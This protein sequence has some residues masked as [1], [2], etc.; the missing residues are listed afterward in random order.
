MR[1]YRDMT[2]WGG[3]GG[4]FFLFFQTLGFEGEADEWG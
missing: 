1:L 4:K 2:H 3:M